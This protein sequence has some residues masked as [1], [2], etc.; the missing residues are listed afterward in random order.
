MLQETLDRVVHLEW[1]VPP[2]QPEMPAVLVRRVLQV[3]RDSLEVQDLV[4][5]LDN[6][7]QLA[8]MAIQDLPDRLDQ[9]AFQ[10]Q[11]EYPAPRDHLDSKV[12]LVRQGLLELPALQAARARRALP[13]QLVIPGLQAPQGR[14][15][16]MAPLE[17]VV[18]QGVPAP[19]D[20]RVIQGPSA[21][22]E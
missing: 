11:W 20:L 22:S 3:V 1:P 9:L 7:D 4:D 2:D 21:G 14:L 17:P 18:L 12:V 15:G 19:Q 10:E 5:L 8:L 13:A 16:L 6:Q